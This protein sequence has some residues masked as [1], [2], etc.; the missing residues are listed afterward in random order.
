M[1]ELASPSFAIANGVLYALGDYGQGEGLYA[2]NAVTGP[3]TLPLWVVPVDQLYYSCLDPRARLAVDGGLV[4]LA[5][6]ASVYALLS[7]IDA[8]SG[9]VLYQTQGDYRF[10]IANGGL[11]RTGW[12][13]VAGPN[14]LL[15][16][17]FYG[18]DFPVGLPAVDNGVAVWKIEND[19][20][21]DWTC[22][23][24]ALLALRADDGSF[25]WERDNQDCDSSDPAA[26]G[27]VV[28]MVDHGNLLAL[29]ATNGTQLW[30][31]PGGSLPVVA[32]AMGYAGCGSD[33]CAFTTA[34][35]KV[36]WRAPEGGWP[37]A[38]ANG[39]VY[40][41]GAFDVKTGRRLGGVSGIVA[42]GMVYAGGYGW[43][44]AYGPPK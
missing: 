22:I 35:G 17:G 34:D 38:S 33:L 9:T 21:D 28:Y 44:G 2:F 19:N 5:C 20:H 24:T 30:S 43:I 7:V 41:N 40:A 16:L 18:W 26:G 12:Q 6:P 15:E 23:D 42:D 8:A 14:W 37:V 32:G 31:L 3:E 29:N 13:Y 25:L 36:V 10:V 27:G 4:Y 1:L 39:V 11:Y